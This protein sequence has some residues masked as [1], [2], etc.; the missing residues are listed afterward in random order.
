MTDGEFEVLP[1]GSEGLWRKFMHN[2]RKFATVEEILTA[3][4]SKRYTRSRLDRMLM[5]AFLGIDA[6]T[7]EAPAPYTRVLAFND[8]GRAVLNR[9]KKTCTL[10]NAGEVPDSPYWELEKR[11]SDLYGLFCTDGIEPPG[12]EEKRRVWYHKESL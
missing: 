9:A 2:A 5:C 7:L 12:A 8:R 11:A 1:Y 4:K 6:A 3:T 10:V